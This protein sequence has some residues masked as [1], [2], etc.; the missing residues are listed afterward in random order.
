[1]AEKLVNYMVQMAKAGY[2]KIS[3]KAFCQKNG[4]EVPSKT[5]R[6]NV[7]RIVNNRIKTAWF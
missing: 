3:I 7:L 2:E 5:A 4:I 1:M 6:G